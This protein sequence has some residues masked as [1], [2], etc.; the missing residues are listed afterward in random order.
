MPG[1]IRLT[2]DTVITPQHIASASTMKSLRRACRPGMN[3]CMISTEPEKITS[4][5]ASRPRFR[6]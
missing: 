5:I 4:R 1:R 3:S 6:S 2:N